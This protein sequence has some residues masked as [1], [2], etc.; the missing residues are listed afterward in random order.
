MVRTWPDIYQHCRFPTHFNPPADHHMRM[1]CIQAKALSSQR[2]TSIPPQTPAPPHSPH[3]VAVHPQV[4]VPLLQ[5]VGGQLAVRRVGHHQLRDRGRG[6]GVV[7]QQ[8]PGGRKCAG[9]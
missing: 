8:V 9:C 1:A 6:M 3:L 7:W 4:T 5:H 2:P